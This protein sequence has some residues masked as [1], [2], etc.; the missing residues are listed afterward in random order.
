MFT[1]LT[2][3]FT[4]TRGGAVVLCVAAAVIAGILLLV[5]LNSYRDSVNSDNDTSPVLVAKALIP[6]GTAGSEIGTKQLYQGAE[7]K[8]KDLKTGALADPAYLVGRVA[9]TDI[10][11]GEQLTAASFSAETTNAI[12]TKITGKQRAISV[13]VDNVHGSLAELKPGDHVD[14]YVGLG[15]RGQNGQA[16]VKLFRANVLVMAVPGKANP[17]NLSGSTDPGGNLILRVNNQK[18]AAAFA[19]AADNSQLWFVLR[20]FSGAKPT[21]PATATVDTLLK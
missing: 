16:L 1:N 4:N 20:P 17:A 5:Y 7:F 13:S 10:L 6:R 14:I 9:V 8:K 19:Y 21:T 12:N 18:D 15:G 2:G 11:P 3:R